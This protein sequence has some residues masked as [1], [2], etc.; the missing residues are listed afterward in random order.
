PNLSSVN[1]ETTK[2][3]YYNGN[4]EYTLTDI[5]DQEFNNFV[6][7][8]K[9]HPNCALFATNMK[10]VFDN[11]LKEVSDSVSNSSRNEFNS[12]FRQLQGRL[13]NATPREQEFACYLFNRKLE[14]VK[15]EV[16]DEVVGGDNKGL[17]TEKSPSAK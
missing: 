2:I 6:T 3:S 13:I 16:P 14:T 12:I 15:N 9:Q 7:K 11:N 5:S 10:K 8:Y 17:A 4:L 1:A